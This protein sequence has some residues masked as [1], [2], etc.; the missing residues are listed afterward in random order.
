[1][2]RG[3]MLTTR[4]SPVGAGDPS[5][6]CKRNGHILVKK[7]DPIK[8]VNDW[9][10]QRDSYKT[11]EEYQNAINPDKSDMPPNIRS[12]Q[13]IDDNDGFGD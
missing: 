5:L 7:I 4:L 12:I 13:D 8:Q 10:Y 2:I 3:A 9:M 6:Y 1:M 11:E